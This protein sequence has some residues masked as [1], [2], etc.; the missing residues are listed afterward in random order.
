MKAKSIVILA[1]LTIC[2]FKSTAQGCVAIRGF[3]GCSSGLSNTFGTSKGEFFANTGFRYFK[4]FRHFR[5][6]HEEKDRIENGTE[7]IN[8]SYFLDISLT[9]GITDRLYG[10]VTVPITYHNRS[11]MYEHGG[12]PPNGLGDRNETSARGLSDIRMGIGYWLVDPAKG[13]KFNY[14]VG[15]GLKLPTGSY[16]YKD[17]FHNQGDNKDETR[18][19]VVDQSIQPGDGGTGI[20]LDIQGYHI[21]SEKIVLTSNLFYLLNPKE[22][23][24]VLTRSGSSEFS[25]PDQFALRVGSFYNTKIHGFSLYAGGRLEGVPSDDLIGGSAGYRRPGY[26]ISVEPGLAYSKNNF[27]VNASIPFAIVRNRVQSYSDKQI[28]AE[29]GE[30]RN[31]DAAFADYLL[32]FTFTYRFGK[33]H[34]QDMLRD[35]VPS[36]NDEK[37]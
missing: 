12:N 36:W 31:G 7:V 13:K 17:N 35:F 10:T 8:K 9:Y 3:S 1:V 28:T 23:N 22:T 14:A 6:N 32:N 24:G 27:A 20:T 11:S 19:T 29:T 37:E 26:A 5:G 30:Y 34:G 2:S 33:K 18:Y 16:N 21:L 15:L 25:C 4:S